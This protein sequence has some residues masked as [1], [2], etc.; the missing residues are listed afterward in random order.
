MG[1]E[2]RIGD[3]LEL[4]RALPPESVD[5]IVT[6]PPY[7]GLRDYNVVGQMG[8][9][10]TLW[11]YLDLMVSL[12]RE[13]RRVLKKHGT[14]WVNMGDA[15]CTNPGNGRGSDE[16]LNLQH[17]GS[18]PHR[19][20]RDRRTLGLKPKDLLGMPWRLAFA[21][22]DDGWWLRQDIVW[23]K[24]NPTPE[25]ARDRCTKSHEYL[26]ILAKSRRYYWDFDAMQEP[27]SGT[28]HGR[29]SGVNPKARKMP[30]NWDTGPG[31]HGSFH[32]AGREKGKTP[33][34]NS[35]MHVDRDVAHAT[36]PKKPR[37]NES[38]SAAVRCVTETRNKRS[39]WTVATEAFREAH[40]ATF[41]TALIEP[42]ILAG[43]PPGGL[44]LDPFAGSGTTGVVC[45]RNDRNFLGFELNPKYAAM[46]RER[47][48]GDCP[49]FNKEA[50]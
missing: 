17:G 10:P 14:C 29:G 18:A 26:F 22:Q 20:G 7:W 25:P 36:K 6:S 15:Y 44:V 43:C 39:V 30:D 45:L 4:T 9:E 3:A 49:L 23:F 19:S 48:L 32:R 24:S 12:F 1:F 21:L 37:Q 47:I 13:L 46:A 11:E 28:A 40:F 38:F 33:G 50:C 42:C 16:R 5:C 41:P 8:L 35:R 31:G 27:V 2:I 34:K